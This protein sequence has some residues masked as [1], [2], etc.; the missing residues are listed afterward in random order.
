MWISNGPLVYTLLHQSANTVQ[1]HSGVLK[2]AAHTRFFCLFFPIAPQYMTQLKR[3]RTRCIYQ[4][5]S[6]TYLLSFNSSC[7]GTP[8]PLPW[9]APRWIMLSVPFQYVAIFAL[10]W[11]PIDVFRRLQ[12]LKAAVYSPFPS[13]CATMWRHGSAVTIYTR[14]GGR[15]SSC[16]LLLNRAGATEERRP[17]LLFL[18]T[19]RR[20]I[21][22]LVPLSLISYTLLD[23]QL[24]FCRSLNA[25]LLYLSSYFMLMWSEII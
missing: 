3:G 11:L 21:L 25:Y 18:H 2:P 17:T 13:C 4:I 5:D 6:H 14:A 10:P 1:V 24:R 20:D 19:R 8:L 7:V 9:L 12:R 22:I 23:I 15:D 16:S